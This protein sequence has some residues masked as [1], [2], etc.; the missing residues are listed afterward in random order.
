MASTIKDKKAVLMKFKYLLRHCPKVIA[1]DADIE[2]R[3]IDFINHIRKDAYVVHNVYKP[4]EEN[5]ITEHIH[6]RVKRN[7]GT[8]YNQ[9]VK[10]AVQGKKLFA[11]TSHSIDWVN[12][13]KK[14]LEGLKPGIKVFVIHSEN[15]T[16]EEI[17]EVLADINNKFQEYDVVMATT[18]ISS[19]VDF[20]PPEAYFDRVYGFF[21]NNGAINDQ[22]QLLGRVRKIKDNAIYTEII[23]IGAQLETDRGTIESYI[24][25]CRNLTCS[26]RKDK[27][28]PKH[29]IREVVN[30]EY[31]TVATLAFEKD[32]TYDLWIDGSV[33]YNNERANYF[34]EFIKREKQDK[35]VV[36]FVP[37]AAPN[38]SKE[39]KQIIKGVKFD[40]RVFI[41]QAEEINGLK[42]Q[43]IIEKSSHG[44]HLEAEEKAGLTKYSLRKFYNFDGDIDEKFIKT[45]STEKLKKIYSNQK[46]LRGIGLEQAILNE[47]HELN[48]LVH[49]EEKFNADFVSKT[50]ELRLM[51]DLRELLAIPKTNET[52]DKND[53][54]ESLRVNASS[55]QRVINLLCAEQKVRKSRIPNVEEW[56]ADASDCWKK[57]LRFTNSIIDSTIGYKIAK[58]NKKDTAGRCSKYHL[59]EGL[60]KKFTTDTDDTSKPSL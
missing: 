17:K 40:E 24:S 59:V 39:L 27:S 16:S 50:N 56:L 57:T 6:Y 52:F 11:G 9:F 1:L 7:D 5:R 34:K 12:G 23:K 33:R 32:D 46:I 37:E 3:H 28:D 38:V 53:A 20:N 22:R 13:V 25:D 55:V 15:N 29:D 30:Y 36:N 10:D 14:Q 44:K 2:N 48:E 19:G 8:F 49:L 42:A 31:E 54:V 35:K 45:Y 21:Y 60:I 4:A 43:E 41:A 51:F 58:F 18:C 26:D 47:R